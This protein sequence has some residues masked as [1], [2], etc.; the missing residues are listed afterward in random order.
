MCYK[1]QDKSA[2]LGIED[3]EMSIGNMKVFVTGGTGFVGNYVVETLLE[4]GYKVRV[5]VRPGSEKRLRAAP[6]VEV[7]YGDILERNLG[8]KMRDCDAVIHLVGIIREF[9]E[10][11]I[12]FRALHYE[13]TVNALE[14][15]KAASIKRFIHMSAL[16]ASLEGRTAYFQT[17][18]QA[19]AAVRESG[20]TYTVFK[21][22]V[23]YGPYDHFTTMFA[24]LIRWSPAIFV[25]GSGLYRLQP[26]HVKTVAKGFT[27]ALGLPNTQN[28]TYEVGGPEP[29]EY[30]KILDI[31]AKT[32]G[33]RWLWKIHLPVTLTMFITKIFQGLAFYPLTTEMITM[34]LEESV[35]SDDSFYEAFPIEPI[36]FEQGIDYLK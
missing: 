17:K 29:L 2:L 3:Q 28:K 12:T 36:K 19:E 32:L 7:V 8:H 25:I 14:A 11:G 30:N 27:L 5:L 31:I 4:E 26:V 34:L 13:A 9:P 23:I 1:V 16:G 21:P 18:A 24:R 20:L 22:S 15:A 10:E 6:K 33:K 35:I